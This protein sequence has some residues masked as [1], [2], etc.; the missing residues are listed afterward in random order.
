MSF[1]S[2]VFSG[3][4]GNLGND[5]APSNIFSDFGSNAATA[6]SNPAFDVGLALTALTAG[7][8]APALLGA[9]VGAGALAAGG[10]SLGAADAAAT[11]FDL[12]TIGPGLDAAAT[13]AVDIGT[14]VVTGATSAADAALPAASTLDAGTGGLSF[15]ANTASFSDSGLPLTG[16][17]LIDPTAA[18][19]PAGGGTGAAA[20]DPSIAAIQGANPDLAAPGGLTGAVPGTAAAGASNPSV[21][22]TIGSTLKS[23][24]PYAG[25]AG[26]GLSLYQGYEQNQALKALN[27]QEQ[28]R[29]QQLDSI[30]AAAQKAA[31]PI[32]SSGSALMDYLT[33]NTLPPGFQAQVDQSVAAAK[34]QRI[35]AAASMG[36]ST[37]PLY[38]T[39]LAQDLAAI[40]RQG[41]ELKSNLETQLNQAGQQM[42]QTA[43]QL[44][45]TGASATE[46][47]SQLP[48]MVQNLDIKLAQM[49]TGAI[50]AFAAAM[51]GGARTGQSGG[52]SINVNPSTGAVTG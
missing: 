1:F 42:V 50:G 20:V 25:A 29:T 22:G 12:G 28:Q 43:N 10:A 17:G 33:T 9:D 39:A 32:L 46:I 48:I 44:L 47:A 13:G 3:N 27:A 37:D 4:F 36:Q 41:I 16:G 38:N 45:T 7:A 26:L 35:Q 24:A 15:G 18:G 2:D 11:G 14:P 40:D 5:L 30:A 21:L 8:A 31:Q 49:T 23:A 52:F 6:F 34:A 19:L 51:N